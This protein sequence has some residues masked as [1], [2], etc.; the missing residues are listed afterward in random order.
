[1]GTHA[2]S[3]VSSEACFLLDD[4]SQGDDTTVSHHP[5]WKPWMQEEELG[6]L[7][8]RALHHLK[9]YSTVCS[10]SSGH[11]MSVSPTPIPSLCTQS[12]TAPPS[13]SLWMQPSTVS[14]RA[15]GYSCPN[16]KL[17]AWGPSITSRYE[18]LG[19]F[20]IPQKEPHKFCDFILDLKIQSLGLGPRP[21]QT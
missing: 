20:L 8:T 1:M 10:G 19:S 15:S 2:E 7:L 4:S 5:A 13:P 17:G 14:I 6:V 9:V 12:R 18:D 21:L 11:P 3:C 16:L